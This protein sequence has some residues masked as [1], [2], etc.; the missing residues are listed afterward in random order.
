MVHTYNPET[1]AILRK[2]KAFDQLKRRRMELLD[3][4]KVIP[5]AD[6]KAQNHNQQKKY[7]S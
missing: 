4:I 6:K 2:K 3:F 1:E 5:F 7:L